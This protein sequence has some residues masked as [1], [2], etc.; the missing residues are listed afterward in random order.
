LL[1]LSIAAC[2]GS[3]ASD[4]SIVEQRTPS[5]VPHVVN[6]PPASRIEP[7]WDLQEELRIGEVEGGGPATFGTIKA[8]AVLPDERIAVLDAQAQEI[9]IFGADGKHQRT[10]GRK[11]SGPGELSD[12]NGLL[13]GRD[14]LMRV[15]DPPNDRMSF[16]HPDSGFVKSVQQNISGWHYIWNAVID[17]ADHVWESALLASGAGFNGYN[18]DGQWADTIR[19]PA[20]SVAQRVSASYTWS[21]ATGGGGMGIPFFPQPVEG[22]D[23][24]RAIWAKPSFDNDYRIV[25][26]TFRGDTTLIMESRRPALPVTQNMRDSAIANVRKI[27]GNQDWSKIPE[28]RPIVQQIFVADN[29]DVWVKVAASDTLT[30]FDVFGSNG[31]YKGTAVTPLRIVRYVSPPVV[32]SDRF[33]AV[34]LD[35]LDVTYIVRARIVPRK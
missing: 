32:R 35:D 14:G 34:V 33:W 13:L 1:L 29:G 2:G 8:F 26:T 28:T 4:W 25:R 7:T 6:T 16:F 31:R 5:G 3:D 24:R 18:P 27:A 15:N 11:G 23:P 30:T 10:F 22:M 9:R 17:T 19:F 21:H 20:R 12:A